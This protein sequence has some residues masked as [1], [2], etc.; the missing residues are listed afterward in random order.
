M[1]LDEALVHTDHVEPVEHRLLGLVGRVRLEPLVELQTEVA[2]E[3]FMVFAP[4]IGDRDGRRRIIAIA[5]RGGWI[6]RARIIS[7]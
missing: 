6:G 1:L 3:F 7:S 2:R 5:R 4:K